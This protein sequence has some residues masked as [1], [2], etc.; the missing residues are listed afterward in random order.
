MRADSWTGKDLAKFLKIHDENSSLMSAFP[1]AWHSTIR[2][3]TY[4][5]RHQT[6]RTPKEESPEFM[7]GQEE[8]SWSEPQSREEKSLDGPRD[9]DDERGVTPSSSRCPIR[10]DAQVRGCPPP[11]S[12]PSTQQPTLTCDNSVPTET[13]KAQEGHMGTTWENIIGQNSGQAARPVSWAPPSWTQLS[14]QLSKDENGEEQAQLR[15]GGTTPEGFNLTDVSHE[16]DIAFLRSRIDR[17]YSSDAA[18]PKLSSSKIIVSLFTRKTIP[19]VRCRRE[20]H[21]VPGILLLPDMSGSCYTWSREAMEACNAATKALRKKAVSI[22]HFNGIY[23]LSAC[24]DYDM[25]RDYGERGYGSTPQDFFRYVMEL[26]N[27]E[28]IKFITITTDMD[29]LDTVKLLAQ[30]GLNIKV[31]LKCACSYSSYKRIK[32][33]S[34]VRVKDSIIKHLF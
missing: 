3:E 25:T 14:E 30:T 22:P 31:L 26:V 12:Q 13:S 18:I 5:A 8:Y 27:R 29:S 17:I 4:Q 15:G 16:E 19:Q 21:A 20:D 6:L 24:S 9:R 28:N 33:I 10:T 1:T 7:G 2:A 23:P 11:P 32:G 34:A